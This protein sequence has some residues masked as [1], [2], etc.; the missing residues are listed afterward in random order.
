MLY[1]LIGIPKGSEFKKP[2]SLPPTDWERVEG[3]GDDY[4]IIDGGD[5]LERLGPKYDFYRGEIH[6]SETS[7]LIEH[8]AKTYGSKE[9]CLFQVYQ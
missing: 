5:A 2:K 6:V 4:V 1:V 8:L 9:F 7:K 3:L